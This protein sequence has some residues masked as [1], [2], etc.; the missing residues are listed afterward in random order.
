MQLSLWRALQPSATDFK[1]EYTLHH[2]TSIS[3][4]KI[5]YFKSLRIKDQSINQSIVDL[6]SA[7]TQS[8]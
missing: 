5:D 2:V 6:Y 3:R 7:Y 4:S 1:V 8:L